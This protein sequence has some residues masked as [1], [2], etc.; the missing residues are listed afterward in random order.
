MSDDLGER[1]LRE[2]QCSTVNCREAPTTTLRIESDY[3][4]V[5]GGTK[6]NVLEMDYCDQHAEMWLSL[7]GTAKTRYEVIE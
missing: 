6:T 4:S 1:T 7:D 3:D 2:E 5:M